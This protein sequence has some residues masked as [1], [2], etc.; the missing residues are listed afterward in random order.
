MGNEEQVEYVDITPHKSIMPKIGRAGYS[1]AQAIAE[2]IDNSL[3]ARIENSKLLI[4]ISIKKDLISI[5]DKGTGMDKH[6]LTRAFSLAHSNKQ[7]KLGEFG[8]GLKT[9]CQSLGKEF[10]ILTTKQGD[11]NYYQLDYDE[12]EWLK[13]EEKSWSR[14]P[15]KILKKE[16]KEEHGTTITIK[17]LIVRSD[18]A[19][20]QVKKDIGNRFSPFIKKEEVEIKVNNSTTKPFTPELLDGTKKSF[21]IIVD[22]K[23]IYGW[24][25]LMK[26]G[27]QKGF[28]GFNVFRKGR[29]ITCYDKI[30]I[31]EHA[32]VA[33]I[34]GE[35]NLDHVPVTHSKREFIKESKEYVLASEALALHFKE[36]VR[37]ARKKAKDDKVTDHVKQ[38]VDNWQDRIA[39][40]MKTEELE[41]LLPNQSMKKPSKDGK[42]KEEIDI[43]KRDKWKLNTP[44]IKISEE[45]K[46][47]RE[48]K[49]K[50]IR[51]KRHYID[52]RG[53][54][55]DF[56]VEY[57]H[58]GRN[59]SWKKWSVSESEGIEIVINTDFPAWL[60]TKDTPFYVVMLIGEALSEIMCKE[61]GEYTPGKIQELK[62]EILR[63]ASELKNEFEEE[64]ENKRDEYRELTSPLVKVEN[65]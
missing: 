40:A 59:N 3:D 24:S 7:D 17:K 26:E 61:S 22:G 62:E 9:S 48:R 12:D 58:L 35:I 32:T 56:K 21:E 15:I 60:S 36:I 31:P 23:K 65:K 46:V 53:K 54:R 2:L 49:P 18:Y 45:E 28:Y 50:K 39:E 47:E 63:K 34:M 1:I 43:E 57:A 42:K 52:I 64:V 13:N 8:L 27:S 11:N 19:I 55:F 33:R 38:E 37:E 20:D 30:G 25:A 4:D 44:P 51:K 6:E 16:N 5:K 41:N 10:S 29:M 14:Y